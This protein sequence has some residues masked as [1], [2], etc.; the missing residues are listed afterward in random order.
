MMNEVYK[1]I[2]D[3]LNKMKISS[4]SLL[5]PKPS[6]QVAA[7]FLRKATDCIQPRCVHVFFCGLGS[8]VTK[9]TLST[10]FFFF[11]TVFSTHKSGTRV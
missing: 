5:L 6:D 10:T 2:V 11:F 1:F 7:T 9:V 4:F 8:F 3:V